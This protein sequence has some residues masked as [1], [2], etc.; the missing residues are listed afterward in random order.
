MDFGG[1]GRLRRKN[2][3]ATFN[4]QATANF[5]EDFTLTTDTSDK[6]IGVILSQSDSYNR[7]KIKYTFSKTVD[8]SQSNHSMTDKELLKAVKE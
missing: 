6:A 2:E 3:M 4:V 5:N 8:K 1:I 7:R